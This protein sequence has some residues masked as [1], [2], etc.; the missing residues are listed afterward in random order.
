MYNQV[1]MLPVTG[2]GTTASAGLAVAYGGWFWVFAA[3]AV[4]T[5][6]GA[7]GA[8]ARTMPAIGLLHREPKQLAPEDRPKQRGLTHPQ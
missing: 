3:I 4:F 5:L 7:F 1:S 8:A 6:V 2:V